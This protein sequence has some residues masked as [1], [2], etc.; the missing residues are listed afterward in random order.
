MIATRFMELRKRRGLMIALI[1]VTIGIPTVF[2]VDPPPGPRR[3]AEVL[4][5]GRWLRHLH[6][7]R[8]RCAV[9]L[10][11]H[12]G[13]HLGLHGRIGRPDRGDVPASRG[14][15]PL[16]VGAL[17]GPDPAGLAIIVPLVAVG[18][19]IVCAVCVVRRPDP[20]QLPGRQRARR[21]VTGRIRDTGRRTTR[22]RC[23]CN[24][25]L[26][27]APPTQPAS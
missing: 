20:D 16:A 9:R 3:C 19:T 7:A 1:V 18:F 26:R 4:R 8:R 13:R 23:I 14:D 22:T 21:L 11:L 12:R 5:A 10:R 6:R 24:F 15:R 2:L 27:R 25:P 17:P